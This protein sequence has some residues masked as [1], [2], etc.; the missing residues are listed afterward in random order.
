[1]LSYEDAMTTAGNAKFPGVKL[2][3][4]GD[5]D[6]WIMVFETFALQQ[7]VLKHVMGRLPPPSSVSRTAPNRE[8]ERAADVA[9]GA[10]GDMSPEVEE[11]NKKDLLGQV[12]L[13]ASM[14]LM[15]QQQF[16]Q[17]CQ[18]TPLNV[19]RT[20]STRASSIRSD[21]M[22]SAKSCR[23]TASFNI[24][25]CSQARRSWSTCRKLTVW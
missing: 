23:C 20:R 19:P 6:T 12:L 13:F 21:R 1:M 24:D 14:T 18:Q 9:A 3:R 11:W 2:R 25:K 7:G 15:S 5:L 10:A 17:P 16:T 22:S 8:D 4:G